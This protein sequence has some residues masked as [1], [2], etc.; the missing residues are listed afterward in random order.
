MYTHLRLSRPTPLF[1]LTLAFL[2]GAYA[3]L[4]LATQN[5]F[6]ILDG[7]LFYTMT[8]D[9][10]ANH[11]RLPLTTSYNRLDIP[12]AYPPLPF[13]L[14]GGI[15]RLTGIDL[16]TLLRWLPALL[17]LLTIP[18][19]YLMARTML[20]S[21]SLGALA[22]LI[23]AMLP[24]SWEWLIM[25]GGIT[26][27]TG[28][29]FFILFIHALYRTFH[30]QK[31]SAA[32]HAGLLGGLVLLSH[33]ER[34]LHAAVAGL[35]FWLWWGRTREGI[36][37][38]FWIASIT[39][40]IGALWWAP[41][42]VRHGIETLFLASQAAGPRWL[43]WLFLLQVNFTDEQIVIAGLL[44][45]Y[46]LWWSWKGGEKWLALWLFLI[47]LSD[48][49]S[50]P[51]LIPIPG[52]LLIALALARGMFPL[53]VQAPR[54]ERILFQGSG[55]LFFSYLLILML[56]NLQTT[57]L[58]LKKLVLSHP[59]RESLNW[60]AT[61]TPPQARFLALDWYPEPA[62]S[63]VLEWFPTLAGRNNVTTLQ[64]R[65]WLRGDAHFNARYRA[66]HQLR[67]CLYQDIDCLE[68][69]SLT[70]QEKFDYI[71]INLETPDGKIHRSALSEALR[72]SPNYQLVYESPEVLIFQRR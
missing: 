20:G 55:R 72:Q 10:L 69:W 7:G 26:R 21:E 70:H 28:T 31:A 44:T 40:I 6:P 34:A 11:W 59:V 58:E 64:G 51:H 35:L 63:P 61:Y 13:Y 4:T 68:K 71:Y 14:L 3:R 32:W 41:L 25:G 42:L 33:P 2:F 48:P 38:A 5:D 22:T 53:L 65:E 45:I 37:K 50:A 43:F 47:M 8:N 9:L 15:H 60:I 27:A 18:A 17:S 23:F 67:E 57:L 29:L 1:L 24:R 52:S 49:R 30:D 39:L 66:D 56:Y 19:F 62:A 12:F 54:W 16:L 46:G 36:Q